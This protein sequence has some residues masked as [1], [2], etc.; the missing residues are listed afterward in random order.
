MNQSPRPPSPRAGV[1]IVGLGKIGMVYDLAL[2]DRQY[3]YSH[4]RAFS[5]HP[6][7]TL[8]GGVDT[9]AE[10]RRLFEQTYE[11]PAYPDIASAVQAE[12]PA[13]IVIAVPTTLHAEMVRQ[14]LLNATPLVILCE[15]PIAYDLTEARTILEACAK[16]GVRLYV[17]YVR[18]SDPGVIQVKSRL[19][20]GAIA[21][22]AKGVAWYSKGL[23]H[24]GSHLFNLL[25]YW[26]G[27]MKSAAVLDPGRLA[28]SAGDAEPDV[29]VVFDRGIIVFMA[30]REEDFSHYTIELVGSNGRLRYEQGGGRIEWQPVQLHPHLEGYTV[31]S[32][33]AELIVS[34]RDRYQW[35]VVDE[36]AAVM[37]E[38]DGE[39]CSGAAAL[40][41][42]ESLQKIMN[43]R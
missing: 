25:E 15:K 32:S 28:D 39:L 24:N 31:L 5:Q 19:E 17:N 4:A 29:R 41:T 26:L 34:G 3:V 22:P 7:F 18:R 38:R 33:E 42:L 2:S 27:A 35:H 10:C 9:D 6:R 40:A 1:L 37:D 21:L 11:C 14:A 30:V 13:V 8:L 20:S 23:L 36:L 43:K 12:I 16:R